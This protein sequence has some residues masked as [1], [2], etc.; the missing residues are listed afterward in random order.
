MGN[1]RGAVTLDDSE[2]LNAPVSGRNR[3]TLRRVQM[4]FQNADA[5]LNPRQS[6]GEILMAP[7][8]RP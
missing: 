7:L 6:I 1:R 8:K 2:S 5:S 3:E 4:I